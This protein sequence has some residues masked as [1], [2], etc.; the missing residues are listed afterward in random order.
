MIEYTPTQIV[1]AHFDEITEWRARGF[2]WVQI[3][4]ELHLTDK[5]K[6]VSA[7]RAIYQYERQRRTTPQYRAAQ[8][9]VAAHQREITDLRARG[10]SWR[11]V[12]IMVS[13]EDSSDHLDAT[14]E[15]A[16]SK[17]PKIEMLIEVG[18]SIKDRA[19]RAA[20]TS[21]DEGNI[22]RVSASPADALVDSPTPQG[23]PAL[24]PEQRFPVI[25][26]P[27]QRVRIMQV[28]RATLNQM[29]HL[30]SRNRDNEHSD[31]T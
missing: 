2:S 4:K 17:P 28:I 8:R 5:I 29:S 15:N 6:N 18:M 20:P 14:S 25:R 27:S 26:V 11:D 19:L 16:L 9:W 21:P 31:E 7:L 23:A 1:R 12:I 22:E 13:S 3:S 24:E 10:F 30:R